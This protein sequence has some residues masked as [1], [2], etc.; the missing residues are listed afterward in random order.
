MVPPSGK[1]LS[2]E[3]HS[4]AKA[5]FEKL[6]I[7]DQLA[8]AAAS[9][10]W[11]SPSSIQE[12]AVPLVLQGGW[13]AGVPRMGLL[14][15]AYVRGWGWQACSCRLHRPARVPELGNWETYCTSDQDAVVS[16][17]ADKD[18]IGLAQTGSGKTGAFALPILQASRG[19]GA[20]WLRLPTHAA[21]AACALTGRA[22]VLLANAATAAAAAFAA[23]VPSLSRH[24]LHTHP[25]CVAPHPPHPMQALLDKP[26]ALFALVLSPTR[27]LA[28]Q[29]AEQ[30]EAL[31]AGIG[32]KCAVLVGGIDM[33]AQASSAVAVHFLQLVLGS[34]APGCMTSMGG[35]GA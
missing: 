24:H 20:C 21:E 18:V 13:V 9:L 33:M 26:Q 7:C 28:I 34:E 23:V 5:A 3:E 31:G 15:P 30:F 14:W 8:E 32:V 17:P 27:E 29:I 1:V 22:T 19:C 10:G 11:K 4:K 25:P 6:G 16:S 35:A 12:Q 2:E